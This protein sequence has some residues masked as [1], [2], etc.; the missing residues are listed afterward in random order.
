MTSNFLC[1]IYQSY[2]CVYRAARATAHTNIHNISTD[3]SVAVYITENM[4]I[5]AY[6]STV[7]KESSR[8]LI[9]SD[10]LEDQHISDL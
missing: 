5:N 1:H 7:K 8:N 10:S 9:P 3:T 4:E 6:N 2:I